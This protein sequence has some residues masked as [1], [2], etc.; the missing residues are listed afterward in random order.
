[1]LRAFYDRLEAFYH[2]DNSHSA[3]RATGTYSSTGRAIFL[4]Y[5]ASP[6]TFT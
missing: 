5:Y 1:M 4:L 6:L 3:R 2:S